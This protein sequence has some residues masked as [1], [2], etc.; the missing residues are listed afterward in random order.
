MGEECPHCMEQ[1]VAVKKRASE[2]TRRKTVVL[3]IS[4]SSPDKNAAS[5]RLGELGFRLL[6]DVNHSNARR[7]HSYDDFE[8]IELHSTIMI[9]DEGRIHWVRTGGDAFMEIDFLLGEL[10][11]IK[12]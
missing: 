10:D 12:P 8:G 7:F 5:E 1:L 6:S 3:A 2:L 9:D 4:G 11:T